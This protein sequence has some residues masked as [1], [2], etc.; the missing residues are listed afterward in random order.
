MVNSGLGRGC[1]ISPKLQSACLPVQGFGLVAAE[2]REDQMECHPPACHWSE[3]PKE[4]LPCPAL[5]CL[6]TTMV[7]FPA[8]SSLLLDG[9]SRSP[10]SSPP[11]KSLPDI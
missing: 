7:V 3:Q 5:L 8:L 9:G 10:T 4:A 2:P 11:E 1:A 6:P